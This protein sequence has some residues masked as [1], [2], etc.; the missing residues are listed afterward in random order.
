MRKL[1]NFNKKGK[2]KKIWGILCGTSI[3]LFIV[4]GIGFA[5]MKYVH[6]HED[7]D[8][9]LEDT[10]KKNLAENKKSNK[11]NRAVEKQAKA[12]KPEE[13][14][15]P[16][17][18]DNNQGKKEA[19]RGETGTSAEKQAAQSTNQSEEPEDLHASL[20]TLE[21]YEQRAKEQGR[22]VVTTPIYEEPQPPEPYEI[23]PQWLLYD[24]KCSDVITP[25]QKQVIDAQVDAWLHGNMTD[26][27]LR[28]W[29]KNYLWNEIGYEEN[30][31]LIGVEGQY[32]CLWE[33]GTDISAFKNELYSNKSV[34][35]FKA[36]YTEGEKSI[37]GKLKLSIWEAWI[38]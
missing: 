29:M 6:S 15:V 30:S 35:Y 33:R 4:M 14:I 32:P 31:A 19:D 8:V 21:A 10:E 17:T 28:E 1:T 36:I 23:S 9:G 20:D 38:C 27:A 7:N 25:E 2:N 24:S 11:E 13:L 5:G 18:V 34:Y 22:E 16:S 37:S 26:Q 3:I 12:S